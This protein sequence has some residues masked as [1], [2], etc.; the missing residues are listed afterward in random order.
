MTGSSKPLQILVLDTDALRTLC[1]EP[2]S[3]KFVIDAHNR[4]IEEIADLSELPRLCSLDVSFN[5]LKVLQNLGTARELRELKLYNNR[6]TSTKGLR[7]N[8]NLEGL[9]LSENQIEAISTDLLALVKLKTLWLKG[10]RIERVENLTSCRLLMHLDL[11][12][13]RL[14]GSVSSGLANLASLETLNLSDNQLTSIGNLTPLSKLEDLNV[15][16]NRIGSLEGQFPPT[17]ATLRVNG[18]GITELQSLAETLPNLN[19]LYIQDNVLSDLEPLASRFPELE[20]LDI[21]NNQIRSSTQLR[22]LAACKALQDIW[23]VGNPCCASARDSVVTAWQ[24]QWLSSDH[25]ERTL[26]D[27]R[28]LW[29]ASSLMKLVPPSEIEQ[30]KA[31]VDERL[32]KMKAMLQRVGSGGSAGLRE[33]QVDSEQIDKDMKAFLLR[34]LSHDADDN[35]YW[36][37]DHNG[38]DTSGNE[39]QQSED[40]R[41]VESPRID[42]IKMAEQRQPP[43]P[44]SRQGYRSFRMPSSHELEKIRSEGDL[45]LIKAHAERQ[46]ILAADAELQ[47]LK[48]QLKE[49]KKRFRTLGRSAAGASGNT[50]RLA[51]VEERLR[52]AISERHVELQKLRQQIDR[53]RRQRLE[54]LQS[55]KRVV[56]A[57]RQADDDAQHM[58]RE[59][60]A[61]KDRAALLKRELAQLQSDMDVDQQAF[62]IERQRLKLEVER[63]AKPTPKDGGVKVALPGR[64]SVYN[65]LGQ[66]SKRAPLSKEKKLNL[67][68]KAVS[69]E[70]K[71]RLL[72]K[73]VEDTGIQNLGDFIERYNEQERTKAAILAR[74][75]AK[76][77]MNASLTQAI[78]VLADDITRLSGAGDVQSIE[79]TEQPSELKRLIDADERQIN[80]WTHDTQ[81]YTE[82]LKTFREPT[83]ELY[84]ELFPQDRD[85]EASDSTINELSMLRRIGAIEERVM[86]RV[87]AKI[88]LEMETTQSSETRTRLRKYQGTLVVGPMGTGDSAEDDNRSGREGADA[89]HNCR[90]LTELAVDPP[91]TR[92]VVISQENLDESDDSDASDHECVFAET[93]VAVIHP[94]AVRQAQRN[95]NKAANQ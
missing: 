77:S 20:S 39:N 43:N 50:Q 53:V 42:P 46:S 69:F 12:K 22:A 9:F 95:I 47:A 73:L 29:C 38:D 40:A 90:P 83:R 1:A 75:N 71:K 33:P 11:S 88:L 66:R 61:L 32:Q 89:P 5:R 6:L 93:Q 78:A 16:N 34:H 72:D 37:G 3:S 59:L 56:D 2:N 4:A 19:E 54:G 52:T 87:L 17:L 63:I 92:D 51:Q 24:Q 10:N 80:Q 15:A 18:N 8:S 55:E 58:Q 86:Q 67:E 36:D 7:A 14:A 48:K 68:Q 23:L 21:R 27:S 45:A 44:R 84:L 31:D 81:L 70:Q 91:S 28:R 76:S 79:H 74:I 26:W 82:T 57:T 49:V 41:L 13:N 94:D 60:T 62:R 35:N 30:A 65:S 85:G 64:K 25:A